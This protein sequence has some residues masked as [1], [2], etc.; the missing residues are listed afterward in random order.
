MD[1]LLV[2]ELVGVFEVEFGLVYGWGVVLCVVFCVV[3][4]VVYCYFC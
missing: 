2:L 3:C 1:E 4:G